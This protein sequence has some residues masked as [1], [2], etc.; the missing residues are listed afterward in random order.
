MSLPTNYKSSGGFDANGQKVTNLADA[1]SPQ[2]AM[3]LRTFDAKN[4][5]QPYVQAKTYNPDFLVE[6][7]GQLWKCI[8]TTTGQFD[9]T[10]WT[11]I[12]GTENW[13]RITGSYTAISMDTLYVDTTAAPII[14]ALPV[15]PK[16]GDYVR[17]IDSGNADKNSITIAPNGST[18]DGVA[19]NS[20][21]VRANSQITAIYLGGTWV[22]TLD[23]LINRV[24]F[25]TASDTLVANVMYT[26]LANASFNVTLPS[27]PKKGDWVSLTD[28]LGTV[29]SNPITVLASDKQINAQNSFVINQKKASWQLIYDGTGWITYLLSGDALL[30]SKNLSDIPD[31][32]TARSS[33]GLGSIATYDN[34]TGTGQVRLNGQNDLVYQER[35]VMLTNLS[36]LVLT[37]NKLIYATGANTFATTDFGSLARTL[38]AATTTQQQRNAMELGDA[39]VRNV[40]TNTGNLM[41]VG[42]F[43]LG[44]AS[45]GGGV[46]INTYTT[47]GMYLTPST[48]VLNLPSGWPD[49]RNSVVVSG[50]LPYV[51][52]VIIQTPT[53]VA[54]GTKM[55]FRVGTAA[56]TWSVWNELGVATGFGTAATRNV[57]TSAGNLIEVG[58]AF[59]WGPLITQQIVPDIDAAMTPGMYQVRTGTTV[60]TLPLTLTDGI[61][62]T[63]LVTAY[64]SEPGGAAN[65]IEQRLTFTK[66]GTPMLRIFARR[67]GQ[68]SWESWVEVLTTANTGNVLYRNVGTANTNVM[69]VGAFGLG[70]ASTSYAGNLNSL[71]VTQFTYVTTAA[72]NTPLAGV[73]GVLTHIQAS[74]GFA[75]QEFSATTGVGYKRYLISSTWGAWFISSVDSTGEI[76]V[77]PTTSAL[78]GTMKANG[79]AV[80][81]TVYAKLFALIGTTFGAGDGSTTFNLP[82][83]RGEVI[84]GWDDGRGIDTGRVFGSLQLDQMQPFS[85]GRADA[86]GWSLKVNNGYPGS[87][88]DGS[89]LRGAYY[90]AP[91]NTSMEFPAIVPFS[92]YGTP[93]VG[94]ETRARNV[95]L[96]FCIRY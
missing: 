72:T 69:E 65:F 37:A 58:N 51:T 59:G 24:R 1:T 61:G 29:G 63:L 48:G 53:N 83:L 54:S 5:V 4:T 86:T 14:I 9:K 15:A 32:P 13:I 78:P 93:R 73:D 26:M 21:I 39:S 2:D 10:K 25:L 17:F 22:T 45:M 38:L 67:Y 18:I 87:G 60:G 62:G 20:V 91:G 79:A 95:A 12:R 77:S 11:A 40:G 85:F 23:L 81:R 94:T 96:L 31:K 74:A 92:T 7:S 84:R 80:S 43:G 50:A 34:G 6:F 47:S 28:Q 66:L 52:Q 75:T 70:G 33:L 30:A 36:Q 71:A 27:N 55:A 44:G 90:T 64:R 8:G 88:A 82:D 16:S 41:Q 46:D 56:D 19:G 42:A 49:G 35:A 89:S 57:G 76:V 68:D 3:N